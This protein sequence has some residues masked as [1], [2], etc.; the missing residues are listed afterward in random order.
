MQAHNLQRD[1]ID[2]RQRLAHWQNLLIKIAV[3]DKRNKCDTEVKTALRQW[4]PGFRQWAN[5]VL[6]IPA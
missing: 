6:R 5:L 4:W 1:K 3:R 2:K